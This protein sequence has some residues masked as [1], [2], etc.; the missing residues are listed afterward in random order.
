[1]LR[2]G[3][4]PPSLTWCR[5]RSLPP[6]TA[7][8]INGLLLSYYTHFLHLS[9]TSPGPT[10]CLISCERAD[11][12]PLPT[13][14]NTGTGREFHRRNP[15]SGLTLTVPGPTRIS[16]L[17]EM[18]ASLWRATRLSGLPDAYGPL[19]HAAAGRR[20]SLR[21]GAEPGTRGHAP[22]A[23]SALAR[24]APPESDSKGIRG[25]NCG[26]K[27]P[28]VKGPLC[29]PAAPR[30]HHHPNSLSS[31][32]PRRRPGYVIDHVRA[33]K[34]GGADDPW[35]AVQDTRHGWEGNDTSQVF[36]RPNPC[37]AIP[38][39]PSPANDCSTQWCVSR[40]TNFRWRGTSDLLFSE[41]GPTE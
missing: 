30:R 23:P 36:I 24:R 39:Q 19:G 32:F 27:G 21:A 37:L 29:R 15:T 40:G 8:E 3:S 4:D 33:L 11:P 14:S 26:S 10:T 2:S 12:E 20:R 34:E 1:M 7:S 17:P 5:I 9:R 22:P 28:S 38:S 41:N 13:W 18:G 31:W 16:S 25:S 35:Q 6:K